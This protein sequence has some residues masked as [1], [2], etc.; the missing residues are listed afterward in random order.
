MDATGAVALVGIGALALVFL[1]ANRNAAPTTVVNP[2]LGY[3][4]HGGMGYAH[5]GVRAHREHS[6][7]R[8]DGG[9]HHHDHPRRYY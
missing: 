3:G 2:V 6:I 1:T 8:H 9:H 7:R 4:Y 5:P